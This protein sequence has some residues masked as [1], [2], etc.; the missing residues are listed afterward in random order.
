MRG[1]SL[2]V[3]VL[4]SG[5]SPSTSPAPAVSPP[6]VARAPAPAPSAPEAP[7]PVPEPGVLSAG[8]NGLARSADGR[9][10]VRQF[11]QESLRARGCRSVSTVLTEGGARE[12]VWEWPTCLATP[13]QRAFVSADGQAVL[14]IDPRPA[15][16]SRD[17]REAE[18]AA[19][20]LHGVR[21]QALKASHLGA[22]PRV[23]RAPTPHL[24][25][26]EEG[27]VE[28]GARY[29]EEGDAVVFRALDGRAWRLGFSGEGFPPD[30]HVLGET[31]ESLVRYPDARGT[32]HVVRGWDE[33]PERF[34]SQAVAVTAQVE[35]RPAVKPP[36]SPASGT[37]PAKGGRDGE[38]ALAVPDPVELLQKARE[39]ASQ[40]EAIRREQDRLVGTP[41]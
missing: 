21:A 10:E 25:W 34:R 23:V 2:V 6:V 22:A 39:T 32:M 41:P 1:R 8:W 26:L 13:E 36:V 4:L 19:L 9:A 18:V 37:P 14:V 20:Y 7:A 38:G 5:C 27:G 35:V 11:P 31:G 16:S 28:P 17:G 30:A 29:T 40:V 24:R 33:V 12:V 3:A 15:V